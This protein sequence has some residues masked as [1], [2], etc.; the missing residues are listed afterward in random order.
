MCKSHAARR[1]ETERHH[2]SH[3]SQGRSRHRSDRFNQGVPQ[4]ISNLFSASW[5]TWQSATELGKLSRAA[6][7]AGHAWQT[8]EQARIEDCNDLRNARLAPVCVHLSMAHCAASDWAGGRWRGRGR[9]RPL[10]G[11]CARI[12]GPGRLQAASLHRMDTETSLHDRDR[13]WGGWLGKAWKGSSRSRLPA[14]SILLSCGSHWPPRTGAPTSAAGS[15]PRH[16]FSTAP[17]ASSLQLGSDSEAGEGKGSAW[18]G[19]EEGKRRTGAHE[20]RG[21]GV[22][23]GGHMRADALGSF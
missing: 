4:S 15:G 17:S 7:D 16:T 5:F 3:T 1:Q 19:R 20:G 13:P 22:K 9:L 8:L 10:T 18:R 23:E 2:R 12:S 14:A 21:R 11:C 6:T